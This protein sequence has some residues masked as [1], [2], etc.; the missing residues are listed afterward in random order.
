MNIV[1]EMRKSIETLTGVKVAPQGHGFI[2][3]ESEY[4]RITLV[5]ELPFDTG[6]VRQSLVSGKYQ[7]DFI[8][9]DFDR[10]LEMERA[11]WREWREVKHTYVGNYPVQYIDK[12]RVY[13]D[14]AED[15][16]GGLYRQMSEFTLYYCDTL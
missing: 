13:Q 3:G 9:R 8:S 5:S 11:V 6:L 15:E 4:I 7:V 14:F 16:E 10:T 1:A 12:G 2:P